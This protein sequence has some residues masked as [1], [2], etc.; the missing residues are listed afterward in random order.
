V[1]NSNTAA[2]AACVENFVFYGP[3]TDVEMNSNSE[4]CGAMAAAT[5]YLDSNAHFRTS[6]ASQQF[7]L[8]TGHSAYA[9]DR[10]IECTATGAALPAPDTGC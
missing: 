10:Y 1:L 4:F 3:Y 7:L 5:V 8:P 6:L 2:N 9:I